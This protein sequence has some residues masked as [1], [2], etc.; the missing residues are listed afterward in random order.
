MKHLKA[1]A[2]AVACGAALAATMGSAQAA[3]PTTQTWE[4][5]DC[6][7]PAGTPSS[8]TAT[9]AAGTGNALNVVG[10]GSFVV[11]LA[12]NEDLDAYNVPV[13]APGMTKTALV[14]CS[15]IGPRFGTHFTFWGFLTP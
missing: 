3:P 7:G 13:I 9:R 1:L 14:E 8:F 4:F 5:T 12:Y 15:T 2:A 6:S 10:G 11:L